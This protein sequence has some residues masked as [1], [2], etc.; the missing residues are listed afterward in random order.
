MVL[1]DGSPVAVQ[2]PPLTD[3]FG[4]A[5]GYVES[6]QQVC[7]LIEVHVGEVVLME[8]PSFCFGP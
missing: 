4:G 3:V 5:D 1:P 7:V 2:D 6:S 8:K